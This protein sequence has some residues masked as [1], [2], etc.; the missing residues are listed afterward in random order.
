MTIDIVPEYA[1]SWYLL[2]P[3]REWV[4]LLVVTH[5][6]FRLVRTYASR[7]HAEPTQHELERRVRELEQLTESLGA[8][9]QQ[10]LDAERFAVALM[11]ERAVPTR[12]AGPV[13]VDANPPRCVRQG[14]GGARGS[15]LDAISSTSVERRFGADGSS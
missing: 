1:S 12:D 3:L 15:R 6:G 10:V 13:N 7:S 11:L 5:I 2:D 8:H 4:K 9:V 14:P